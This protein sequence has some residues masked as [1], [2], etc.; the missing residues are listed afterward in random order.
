MEKIDKNSHKK[1][2]KW[3]LADKSHACHNETN[4]EMIRVLVEE[5]NQNLYF[6]V[7]MIFIKVKIRLH[8]KNLKVL[9]KNI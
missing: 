9:V 6:S 8:I 4:S 2:F 1:I 5:H 3:L 7:L